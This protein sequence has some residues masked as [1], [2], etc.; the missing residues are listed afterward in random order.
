MSLIELSAYSAYLLI[1][2]TDDPLFKRINEA[3]GQAVRRGWFP[4]RLVRVKIYGEELAHVIVGQQTKAN[5]TIYTDR[6]V[7]FGEWP[8][9]ATPPYIIQRALRYLFS[10][11]PVLVGGEP[12]HE[13]WAPLPDD[14]RRRL[15]AKKA[16]R[17]QREG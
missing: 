5:R 12:G 1:E 13:V 9:E 8:D 10:K 6:P 7:L 14:I 16:E 15:C 11:D 3:V 4:E 17:D 2:A